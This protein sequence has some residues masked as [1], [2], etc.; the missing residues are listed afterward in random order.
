MAREADGAERANLRHGFGTHAHDLYHEAH[1][2]H[3]PPL[4]REHSA[5]ALYRGVRGKAVRKLT[6]AFICVK[7]TPFQLLEKVQCFQA[8]L[9]SNINPHPYSGVLPAVLSV[10]FPEWHHRNHV[11]VFVVGR[12]SVL[13]RPPA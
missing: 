4:L 12:R 7:K 2:G 1:P 9:V 10:K 5:V 13:A 11:A 8:I 6:S 3:Q